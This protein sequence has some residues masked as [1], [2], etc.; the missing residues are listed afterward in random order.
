MLKTSKNLIFSKISKTIKLSK[1]G[2]GEFITLHTSI[3]ISKFSGPIERFRLTTA[4][5]C[6]FY[7]TKNSLYNS[8]TKAHVPNWVFKYYNAPISALFSLV[9]SNPNEPIALTCD[10][11]LKKWDRVNTVHSRQLETRRD[12]ENSSS[13]RMFEL[14]GHSITRTFADKGK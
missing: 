8:W 11:N 9:L 10:S 14:S 5:L 2:G 6:L 4:K 13:Y 3:I 12:Q 7:E 1:G